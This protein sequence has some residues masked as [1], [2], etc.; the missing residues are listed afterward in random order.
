MLP[1]YGNFKGNLS[2]P[3]LCQWCNDEDDVTEHFLTC[4]VAGVCNIDPEHLRNDD[5]SELWRQINDVVK[6]NMDKRVG[7]KRW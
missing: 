6:S 3:R 7:T 5:N 4:K 2:I 1:V